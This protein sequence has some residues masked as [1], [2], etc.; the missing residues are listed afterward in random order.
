MDLNKFRFKL[1]QPVGVCE[2]LIMY[3]RHTVR[4]KCQPT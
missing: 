1:H 2:W 4:Y 3:S